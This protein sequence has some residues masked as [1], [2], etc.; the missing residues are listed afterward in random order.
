MGGM[1]E[2]ARMGVG[3]YQ[4]RGW[5]W[6]LKFGV[7]PEEDEQRL[8]FLSDDLKHLVLPVGPETW[9]PCPVRSWEVSWKQMGV[10]G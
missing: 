5:S 4:G 1:G 9:G 10:F 7:T 2:A 3:M 6:P 8:S